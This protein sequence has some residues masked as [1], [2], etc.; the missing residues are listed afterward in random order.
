M[1]V[2][3]EQAKEMWCPQTPA[4]K[5]GASLHCLGAACM[6]WRWGPSDYLSDDS[7]DFRKLPGELNPPFSNCPEGYEVT[8]RDHFGFTAVKNARVVKRGFCGMAGKP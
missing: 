1:L 8:I 4:I 2:T 6:W 3:E 5:S 7:K